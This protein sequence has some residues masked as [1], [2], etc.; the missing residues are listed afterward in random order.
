MTFTWKFDKQLNFTMGTGQCQK[1]FDDVAISTNR[2]V[3]VIFPIYGQFLATR[4]PESG[5]M[6]C[7]TNIFFNSNLH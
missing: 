1:T 5:R 7:K 6:V 4:K 2:D 3:S